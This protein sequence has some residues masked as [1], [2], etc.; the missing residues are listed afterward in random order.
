MDNYSL[1]TI[2]RL[3]LFSLITAIRSSNYYSKDNNAYYKVDFVEIVRIFVKNTIF[4]FNIVY[5]YKLFANNF[6]I[7]VFSFLVVIFI[8]KICPKF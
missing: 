3:N 7:F 8:Y 5:K 6:W 4:N 2:I 1:F